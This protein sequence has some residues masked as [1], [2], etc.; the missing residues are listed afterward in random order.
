MN[1]K[2]Y[3]RNINHNYLLFLLTFRLK[4]R[5][6]NYD[7]SG[8]HSSP[9]KAISDSTRW[10][11]ILYAAALQKM[12]VSHEMTQFALKIAHLAILMEPIRLQEKVSSYG[13]S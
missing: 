10:L 3:F 9:T 8:I 4:F 11:F 13:L 2:L 12:R 1:S 6:G 5:G 7:R